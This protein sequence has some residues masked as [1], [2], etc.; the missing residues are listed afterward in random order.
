MPCLKKR[1]SLLCLFAP[2]QG[3]SALFCFLVLG[4][5][6]YISRICDIIN[7]SPIARSCCDIAKSKNVTIAISQQLLAIGL[8]QARGAQQGIGLEI[9]LLSLVDDSECKTM[10]S[11]SATKPNSSISK[12]SKEL[13]V[14]LACAQ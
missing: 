7:M 11:L 1:V 3:Y 14:E 13:Y 4:E 8:W 12:P 6:F 5:P 2:I 10:L 9:V